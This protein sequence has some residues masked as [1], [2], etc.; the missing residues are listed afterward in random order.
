MNL[1]NQVEDRLN[2]LGQQLRSRP[3]FVELVK[4]QLEAELPSTQNS[5]KFCQ[6]TVNANN[7]VH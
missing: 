6:S 1:N 5:G 3:T 4:R 2:E 7:I